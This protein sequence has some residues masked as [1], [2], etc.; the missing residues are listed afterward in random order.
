MFVAWL[1]SVLRL[2]LHS[3]RRG[4]IFSL[5]GAGTGA[6]D[7]GWLGGKGAS[8]CRLVNLGHR[9][10]AGFVITRDAFQSTLKEMGLAPALDTLD[11]LLAGWSRATQCSLP[12]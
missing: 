9:V 8:L 3:G 12:R 6:T 7:P 4:V 1:A 2:V 5:L 10:P 11:S